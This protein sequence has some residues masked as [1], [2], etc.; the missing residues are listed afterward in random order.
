VI[1]GEGS[2]VG[3]GSVVLDDVPPNIVAWG[4]PARMVRPA[5]HEDWNRLLAGNR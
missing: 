5:G 2:V 4:N 1:I 3:A